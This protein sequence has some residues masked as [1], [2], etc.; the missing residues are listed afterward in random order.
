LLFALVS[1][2]ASFHKN[3]KE[4]VKE[5]REK[6]TGNP[7]IGWAQGGLNPACKGVQ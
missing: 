6:F 1:I 3:A 2:L 4:I 5:M 7:L